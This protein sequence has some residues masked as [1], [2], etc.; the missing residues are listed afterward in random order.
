MNNNRGVT[1]IEMMVTIAIA[2]I[3]AAV[4]VPGFVD[5]MR[6][7]NLTSMTNDLMSTINHARGEAIK[8]G[9]IVSMCS[10]SNG[11]ACGG[12]WSDGWIVFVDA[13]GDGTVDAGDNVLRSHAGLPGGLYTVAA[14]LADTNAVARTYL[15]F[16]R[17]GTAVNTGSL[18]VCYNSDEATAMRISVNLT[19]ARSAPDLVIASCEAP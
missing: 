13:D 14:S 8:R 1:L 18:A 12:T 19:S 16:A 9:A 7:N 6:R 4:A 17:N 15:Q 3:L 5:F 10:S 11:G 2:A